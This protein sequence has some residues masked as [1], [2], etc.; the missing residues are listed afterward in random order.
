MACLI[1][2]RWFPVVIDRHSGVYALFDMIEISKLQIGI[3]AGGKFYMF[4]GCLTWY[5][6]KPMWI[7]LLFLILGQFLATTCEH[8][9]DL[10]PFN[11]WV[12]STQCTLTRL[13]IIVEKGNFMIFNSQ[14]EHGKMHVCFRY[15]VKTAVLSSH[16]WGFLSLPA[17]W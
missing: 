14:W 17:Q 10:N 12:W 1:Q 6:K 13:C 4:W 9:P 16:Q 5:S 11:W 15:W 3:A 2:I 8:A 7:L